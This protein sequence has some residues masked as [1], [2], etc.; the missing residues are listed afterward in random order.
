[1]LVVETDGCRNI[2]PMYAADIHGNT[3]TAVCTDCGISIGLAGISMLT[4]PHTIFS[5]ISA[6]RDLAKSDVPVAEKHAVTILKMPAHING[7]A[8]HSSVDGDCIRSLDCKSLRL[9]RSTHGTIVV[10]SCLRNLRVRFD[11]GTEMFLL[12]GMRGYEI[13]TPWPSSIDIVAPPRLEHN[14]PWP[15]QLLQTLMAR[16]QSKMMHRADYWT[17]GTVLLFSADFQFV[18]HP[19]FNKHI[20]A[21]PMIGSVQL[22]PTKHLLLGGIFCSCCRRAWETAG[23]DGVSSCT[24]S[25]GEPGM[26]DAHLQVVLSKSHAPIRAEDP[27]KCIVALD[28]VKPPAIDTTVADDIV[29]RFGLVCS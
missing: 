16:P 2:S 20:G 21:E 5:Q 25:C 17:P 15:C 27:K 18:T 28:A 9:S 14:K 13:N 3:E 12:R 10:D 23:L 22:Y 11:G 1:M 7:R 8:T 29:L 19:A 24:I 26:I 6:P 4:C